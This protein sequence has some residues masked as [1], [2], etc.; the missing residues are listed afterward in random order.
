MIELD[1][2]EREGDSFGGRD[3]GRLEI[4]DREEGI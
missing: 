1:G 2:R 3:R 4:R